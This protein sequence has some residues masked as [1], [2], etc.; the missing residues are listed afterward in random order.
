MEKKFYQNYVVANKEEAFVILKAYISWWFQ[1]KT[2]KNGY[3]DE[4]ICNAFVEESNFGND[5]VDNS[6]CYLVTHELYEVL[7]KWIN[8]DNLSEISSMEGFDSLNE[9]DVV[10]SLY[11]KFVG[12]SNMDSLYERD[13]QVFGE[14]VSWY[15]E[16]KLFQKFW[17]LEK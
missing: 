13:L 2:P 4:H 3:M 6:C 5:K 14:D 8:C 7:C 11:E 16:D 17:D 1:G 15:K 12:S 10:K 9:E